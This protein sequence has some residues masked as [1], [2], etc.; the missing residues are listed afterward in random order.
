MTTHVGLHTVLKSLAILGVTSLVFDNP[1]YDT[2]AQ[3]EKWR[4]LVEFTHGQIAE[5]V[6]GYAPIE[7]LWLDA[8]QV[9]PPQQDLQMD[10]LAA[11][12]RQHQPRLIIVD[13][14][15]GGRFENCRTPEQEVP[16]R[17]LPYAWETCMTMGDQWSFKPNDQYKSAHR[18]VHLLV[19]IAGKGG[20]FLLNVGPQ[21]DGQL[22]AAAVQR[23]KEIGEW[24]DVNGEAIY[25]TRPIA[26]YQDGQVVFT[27]RGGIAYAICLASREGEAMPE[28]VSF[29]GLEPAPGSKLRLLG[30]Q[31]SLAWQT[32]GGR[33]TINIPASIAKSPPCQHAFAFQF[34]PVSYQ[35]AVPLSLSG[36]PGSST[37]NSHEGAII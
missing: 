29:S 27:R 8:G 16:E 6:T 7:I 13:R 19:G 10:R 34:T 22:P 1:N 4:R 5:L 26:P 30:S 32:R 23:R 36:W 21:P 24:L 28:Q 14:T 33:T 17:P 9:R 37:S 35:E 11:M 2:L 3:P 31:K 15:V 18:L 12:A 20:N 25:G